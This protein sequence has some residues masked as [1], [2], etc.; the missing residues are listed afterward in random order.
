MTPNIE[1]TPEAIS[2]NSIVKVSEHALRLAV[3]RIFEKIGLSSEDAAEG[4]EVLVMSDLRGVD[5]HGVSNM[6]RTYVANYLNRKLSPAPGWTVERETPSTA[7]IDA[8]RRLG[9]IVGPKAMRLAVAKARNVGMGAVAVRS[10]GHFGAVGHH[11]M[12]AAEQGMVGICMVGVGGFEMSVLPTF[13]AVPM[14]GTNPIAVA[15]PA[16]E[17][18]PFLFDAATSVIAGNKIRNAIRTGDSLKPGWVADKQG[19]PIT[20]PAKVQDRYQ[21]YLLP[22]GGTRD[23]GSHKGYALSM[24][25]EILSSFLSGGLPTML[26][27]QGTSRAFFAAYDIEVFSDKEE[28]KRGMDAMLRKIKNAKPIPGHERVYY[29]GLI[30]AE[31]TIKR[32]IEGIPLHIEVIQWFRQIAKELE[33]PPLKISC[34][35]TA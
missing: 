3:R 20:E 21:Y 33:V 32:R 26:D 31:E 28:F 7:V 8:E 29:P 4:A 6:F 27:N 15:V 10:A 2:P 13:S 23:Q 12:L 34:F 30:E 19:T 17:E 9:I 35:E 11:A 22:L 16:G 24:V 18:A 5:S 1:D 25:A 14:F